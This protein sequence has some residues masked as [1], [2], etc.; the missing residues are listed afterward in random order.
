VLASLGAYLRGLSATGT[1]TPDPS[2]RVTYAHCLWRY[3]E[4]VFCISALEASATRPFGCLLPNGRPQRW[5]HQHDRGDI[6]NGLWKTLA[7]H[8][9]ETNLLDLLLLCGWYHAISFAA[10]A[11]RVPLQGLSTARMRS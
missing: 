4:F 1:V 2:D 9:S 3:S 5:R 7:A 11:T 6:D 8:F 10:R